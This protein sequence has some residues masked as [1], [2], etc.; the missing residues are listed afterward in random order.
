MLPRLSAVTVN[1]R[2]M[3]T[4][5]FPPPGAKMSKLLSRLTPFAATLKTRCPAAVTLPISA[6]WSR[7]VYGTPGVRLDTV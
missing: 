6:K 1:C 3:A 5:A 4:K 2:T 7:A